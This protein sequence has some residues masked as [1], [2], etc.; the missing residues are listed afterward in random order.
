MN[1]K[2]T[3]NRQISE[4]QTC[5][6][7]WGGAKNI[8]RKY[9]QILVLSTIVLSFEEENRNETTRRYERQDNNQDTNLRIAD[10]QACLGW[11]EKKYSLRYGQILVFYPGGI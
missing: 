10:L 9:G 7:V 5:K 3:I 8:T 2:K 1:D 4:S 6:R 11:C